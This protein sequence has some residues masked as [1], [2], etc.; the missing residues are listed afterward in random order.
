[1]EET[2]K[3]HIDSHLYNP[4]GTMTEEFKQ[5][6]LAR[7]RSQQDIARMEMS[8]MREVQEK[9]ERNERWQSLYGESY[10]EWAQKGKLTEAELQRR[11]KLALTED[12]P[13]D[14][15]PIAI[16]PDEYYPEP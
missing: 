15:L 10:D 16:D 14:E 9:Q 13:I 7:G 6:L 12:A 8:K 3:Q 5:S 4:D 11:Q 1:M 2:L